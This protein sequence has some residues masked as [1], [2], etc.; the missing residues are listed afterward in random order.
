MVKKKEDLINTKTSSLYPFSLKNF[1]SVLVKSFFPLFNTVFRKVWLKFIHFWNEDCVCIYWPLAVG[2]AHRHAF[3]CN[4]H[5]VHGTT[6][7]RLT[8]RSEARHWKPFLSST[9]M[10]SQPLGNKDDPI[11]YQNVSTCNLVHTV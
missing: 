4:I 5:V 10:E 7:V 11:K 6:H 2:S 9:E 3:N 8:V 1:L